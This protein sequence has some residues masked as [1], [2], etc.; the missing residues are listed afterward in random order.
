MQTASF[1]KI[2]ECGLTIV[3]VEGNTMKESVEQQAQN[4]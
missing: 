3:S 4:G 1:I 2:A